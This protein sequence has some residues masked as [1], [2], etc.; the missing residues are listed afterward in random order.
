[1]TRDHND[2]KTADMIVCNFLGATRIS[3]GTCMEI[4]FSYAYKVPLL[5][6]MEPSGNP[7]DYLMIREAIGFR[8][9]KLEDAAAVA[10]SILFPNKK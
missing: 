9:T 3:I 6:I 10:M 4:A 1:M 8:V 2:C 7:H 5:M